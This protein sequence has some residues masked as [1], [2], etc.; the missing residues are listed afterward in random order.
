MQRLFWRS[1]V[2]VLGI[3]AAS[4]GQSLGDVARENREKKA[5]DT[6]TAPPEVITNLDLSNDDLPKDDQPRDDLSKDPAANGQA[7]EAAP[8]ASTTSTKKDADRLAARRL[9]EQ[10]R[11]LRQ[12]AE[13]RL[14]QQP[15]H[16]GIA[17]HQEP[18]DALMDAQPRHPFRPDVFAPGL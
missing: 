17:D 11:A 3:T 7:H 5:A 16:G 2:L 8:A 4:Y 9:A 10:K 1:M 6:S 13:Q 18:G 12:S 14:A 15:R